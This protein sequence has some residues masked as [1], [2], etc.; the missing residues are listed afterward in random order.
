MRPG[1]DDEEHHAFSIMRPEFPCDKE[2][3]SLLRPFLELPLSRLGLV[4][5]LGLF[6]LFGF[7]KFFFRSDIALP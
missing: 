5:R 3:P 4:E 7:L 2:I 1:I 6:H